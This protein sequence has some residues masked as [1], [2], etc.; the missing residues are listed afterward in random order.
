[1]PRFPWLGLPE[2]LEQGL[3]WQHEGGAAIVHLIAYR[4]EQPVDLSAKLVLSRAGEIA[5]ELPPSFQP[6]AVAAAAEGLSNRRSRMYSLNPSDHGGSIVGIQGGQVD[7][8]VEVLPPVLSLI[9]VGA[10]HIAQPLAVLG[11]VLGFSVT[12]IDDRPEFA[13]RERFPDADELRV[14]EFV[15][16]LRSTGI[17]RDSFVVLVT[18]GHAHDLASLRYVLTTDAGYIGMIGSK[19]RIRTV[20]GHL[21]EE[22]FTEADLDR[23]YAPVG[24]DIGSHTPQEIAVA[25]AGEMVNIY[26]GGSAPHLTLKHSRDV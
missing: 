20:M 2:A 15:E 7:V 11:K 21:R 5:G 6:A 18:R 8:F 16:G 25:I 23:V 9:I 1:M 3:R 14:A 10:G 4:T 24:I 12:V 13:I 26:R 19:M 22:G 17:T